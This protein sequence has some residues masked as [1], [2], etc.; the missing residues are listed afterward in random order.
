MVEPTLPRDAQLAAE[1]AEVLSPAAPTPVASRT[2]TTEENAATA[3]RDKLRDAYRSAADLH[4][5]VGLTDDEAERVEGVMRRARESVKKL[6]E[7]IE[8]RRKSRLAD[9]R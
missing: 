3:L 2:M 8:A 5:A 6:T 1:L 7:L 4:I 9:D